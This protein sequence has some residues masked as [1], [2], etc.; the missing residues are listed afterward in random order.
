MADLKEYK[1]PCC[2]GGIHFDIGIQKLKCPYCETEFEIEA[3][4][5]IKDEEDSQTDD[6]FTWETTAGSQ[7]EEDDG[8]NLK[9]YELSLIHI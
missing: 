8:N 1:C 2:G 5:A 9:S 3:I 6:I 4:E 7:W